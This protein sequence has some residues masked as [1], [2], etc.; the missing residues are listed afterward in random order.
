M[1][2]G[3]RAIVTGSSGFIGSVLLEELIRREGMIAVGLDKTTGSD[4]GD[5]EI[6]KKM[7]RGADYVFHMAVLPINPCTQNMRLCIETNAIGTL[8]VVE[9]ATANGVKKIIYSSTSAVYGNM[10]DARIVDE[11]RPCNPNSMYG[12]SKLAGELIVKNSGT[13]Y[14]ILC[15]MNVYGIG[16]KSGLI[17]TLLRCIRD[18]VPPTVDGDGQQT[19]DF[20]HVQDIIRANILAADS[21]VENETFNIGGDNEITV[22]DV[23]RAVLEAAASDLVP[24]HK[25]SDS[26]VRRVGSSAKARKLLGY[27]PS[28]DFNT[29]I[30]EMVNEY[31]SKNEHT[32]H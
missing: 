30:K 7:M 1:L 23:V 13:P 14:I 8:N 28:V 26:K 15:Y 31:I 16:Q 20:V 17:P 6:L 12:V 3:K 25:P 24:V 4:I 2:E 11:T 18:N 21:D 19:F 32:N 9:A 10:D 29:K 5:R 27:H 22:S